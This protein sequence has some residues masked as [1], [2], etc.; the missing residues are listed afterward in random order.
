[1][2][3]ASLGRKWRIAGG[4]AKK[5]YGFSWIVVLV[6][7]HREFW[8]KS[9]TT[10]TVLWFSSVAQ[11]RPTVCNPMDCSTP[12]LPVHYQLPE[13][14]QTHAHWVGDA[15]QPSHPLLS[16]S[17]PTFSLSQHQG[18]FLGVIVI[19]WHCPTLRQRRRTFIFPYQVGCVLPLVGG[20]GCF[21][22]GHSGEVSL[23][24][25]PRLIALLTA[26]EANKSKRRGVEPRN[27]TSLGQPADWEDSRLMSQNNHLNWVWMPGSFTEC[28][29]GVVEEV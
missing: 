16:P 11:S 14:T 9:D 25:N 17:P 2:K 12:G 26:Q 6:W 19:P 18:L 28:G 29:G 7:S 1:M 4:K 15:I 21:P 27:T 24:P 8:N 22:P 23:L 20:E 10:D 3:E 13:L 5:R